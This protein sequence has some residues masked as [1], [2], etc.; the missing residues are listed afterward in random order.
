MTLAVLK[1]KYVV[2]TVSGFCYRC[3]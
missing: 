3:W 1:L 2:F